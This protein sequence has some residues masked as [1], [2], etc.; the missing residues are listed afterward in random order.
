MDDAVYVFTIDPTDKPHYYLDLENNDAHSN[1]FL[2]YQ[3]RTKLERVSIQ[4]AK[5][6]YENR[7]CDVTTVIPQNALIKFVRKAP[8]SLLWF[9]SD[10]TK[11]NRM[12]LRSEQS[13]IELVNWRNKK[14]TLASTTSTST[15]MCNEAKSIWPRRI[16]YNKRRINKL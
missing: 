14:R 10:L 5:W 2:F 3:C 12:M 8:A 15:S 11:E 16:R 9:R 6:F 13:G 4:N 1:N 7:I